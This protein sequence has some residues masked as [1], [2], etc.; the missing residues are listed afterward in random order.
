MKN[1]MTQPYCL[2]SE[3]FSRKQLLEVDAVVLRSS[4]TYLL[5]QQVRWPSGGGTEII[6]PY[7]G[8]LKLK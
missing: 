5:H 7:M 3:F 8:T 2:E 1:Q 4:K 6:N